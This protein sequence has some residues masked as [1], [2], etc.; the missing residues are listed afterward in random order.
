MCA[1]GSEVKT[2]ASMTRK[3]D[4]MAQKSA[5]GLKMVITGLRRIIGRR[6]NVRKAGWSK[7]GL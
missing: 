3:C 6:R 7:R 1:E 4:W 2:R 5:V